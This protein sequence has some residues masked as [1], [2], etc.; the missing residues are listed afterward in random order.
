MKRF[1]CSLLLIVCL[2]SG[3]ILPVFAVEGE[4]AELETTVPQTDEDLTSQESM[5]QTD[6]ELQSKTRAPQ[7]LTTSE[8]GIAFVNEMMGGS[9]GG[10]SQLAGAEQ[11]V[12]NFLSRNALSLNRQQFD[13]LIDIV[14]QYGDILTDSYGWWKVITS[15]SYTDPQLASAFCAWVKGSDGAFSQQHLNRRI[16]EA[17]LFLYGSY[18]GECEANFRYLIFN[19]NGGTLDDNTVLCY[20]Y[21][22]TYS[23]LPTASR[24][25]KYFAGWY[26]ASSGGVHV[27]NSDAVTQNNTVYAHWSDTAEADPDALPKQ[28]DIRFSDVPQGAWYYEWVVRGTQLGLFSGVSA[29]EFAPE[30]NM[31]RAM[32]VT[33]LYRMEG[34]PAVTSKAPFTD[35]EAGQWY[36]GA[37]YWAYANGVVNGI[38]ETRFGLNESITRQQLTKMLYRYAHSKGYDCTAPAQLDA[39]SDAASVADYARESM[40]WTVANGI[41]SGDG[42]KLLPNGKATRAQCAK[43]VSVFYDTFVVTAPN[44]GGQP[45]PDPNPQPLPEPP[46]LKTSEAGVQFIKDHEGFLQYAIWD[47]SQY[48]I[49]YGS[50]CDPEDYP[51]GITEE[52]ADYL[53]RVMLADFEQTVDK[54]LEKSTVEHTQAQYDAILSFTYNLGR[55]WMGEQYTVYQY[56]L[57][58]GY[59]EMEFVNTMGSWCKAGGSFVSGLARRRMDEAN[60]Y[61]NGDYTLGAKKYLCI[62][63]NGA[64][65]EPEYAYYYYKT[66]EA[67]GTLPTAQREGYKLLGWYDKLS[68][69]T[70][71]TT[72]TLAPAYGT[73]TLYA[74]WQE[75]PDVPP[76]PDASS[77]PETSSEPAASSEPEVSS[78][79]AS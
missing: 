40:Q 37:I 3:L 8:A 22:G 41:V 58:G 50:R 73:Y 29:T 43:M 19:A 65:G 60:L 15:G 34:E 52:E 36:S 23:S 16:R 24:S 7:T 30:S 75:A 61:L 17:K 54:L 74:R 9:Y 5:P 53:L 44:G 25:G 35:V 71:Y 27:S 63:Y 66:G 76:E 39:F 11:I 32:L 33:V 59:D 21:G 68:G 42:G 56:I 12:N 47:Y 64:K 70:E 20:P 67:L 49:G 46:E 28:P 18:S 26:T 38:T 79:S 10:T 4:Q 72:Q 13:A 55:Q 14:M 31:T 69:G 62:S 57:Y 51:D 1:L 48:S 6:E 45:E 77:E 2:L 78:E